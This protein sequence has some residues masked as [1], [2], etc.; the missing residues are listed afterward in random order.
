MMQKKE[1]PEK[2]FIRIFLNVFL[3]AI[4]A[5]S[6]AF[7]LYEHQSLLMP[8]TMI[9]ILL[10]VVYYWYKQSVF[11]SMNNWIEIKAEVIKAEVIKCSCT[12][13]YRRNQKE[14]DIYKPHITF[15]YTHEGERAI[16]NQYAR[17]YDG[18]DCNFDTTKAEAQ[19]ITNH[20]RKQH[21]FKAHLNTKSRECVVTLEKAKG[22]GIS[23]TIIFIRITIWL[24]LMYKIYTSN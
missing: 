16:S 3:S 20:L 8:A 4:A 9:F 24:F 21:N 17:S 15:R 6:I 22:Y 1:C 13:F 14:G 18:A 11:N 23:Y 5:F 12:S 2:E 19:Q 7:F 10:Q